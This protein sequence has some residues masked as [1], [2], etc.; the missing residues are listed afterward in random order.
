MNLALPQTIWTTGTTEVTKTGSWR[1]A[2]PHYISA[3]AP[4]HQACPMHGDIADTLARLDPDVLAAVGAFGPAL[5]G[6]RAQFGDRLLVADDAVTMAPLVVARL[7]GDELVVLKGSRGVGLERII[8]EL[9]GR[10][11]N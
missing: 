9:V 10:T 11:A 4:C 7:T 3:P 1:A 6:H 2:L 8:P 5:E